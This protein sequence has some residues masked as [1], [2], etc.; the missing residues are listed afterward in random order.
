MRIVHGSFK[1]SSFIFHLSSLK[2]RFTLIELLV[3]IA[4]IAVL[5]GMLLP[6]L[7]K[8]KEKARGMECT[9]NLKQLGMSLRMYADLD[10]G[11][12][13]FVNDSNASPRWSKKLVDMQLLPNKSP[14]T[15]CPGFPFPSNRVG[16]DWFTYGGASSFVSARGQYLRYDKLARVNANPL[17]SPS[18]LFLLTDCYSTS[19]KLPFF[20]VSRDNDRNFSHV[21]FPHGRVGNMVFADGHAAGVTRQSCAE[22]YIVAYPNLAYPMKGGY[23]Y[24]AAS[25]MDVLQQ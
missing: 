16:H 24:D 11:A 20:R 10:S 12:D 9:S 6:S 1:L 8:A 18:R 3:V 21:S 15:Q 2:K 19:E 25:D 5:A 17:P 23:I 14:I 4:I 7:S 13:Y 22:V